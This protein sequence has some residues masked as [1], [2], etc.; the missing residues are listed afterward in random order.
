MAVS[1]GQ[2]D[3]PPLRQHVEN[4]A[5]GQAEAL[6][7]CPAGEALLRQLAQ[8]GHVYLTVK[9]PGVAQQDI[10]LH[11]LE[12]ALHDHVLAAGGGDKNVPIFCGLVHGHD[13]EVLHGGLQSLEGVHLGDDHIGPHALGPHGDALAAPAVARHHHG[14]ARHHQ[15]GGVHDASQEDCP[16]PYLLS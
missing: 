6:N 1:G 3:Q 14:L 7:A 13:P 4:A 8:A 16:V 15:V 12:V 9:V 10:V 5:V 2:V 11:H